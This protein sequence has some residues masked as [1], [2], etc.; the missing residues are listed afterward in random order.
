MWKEDT[1]FSNTLGEHKLKAIHSS[2]LFEHALF[3]SNQR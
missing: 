2:S 3:M 1:G